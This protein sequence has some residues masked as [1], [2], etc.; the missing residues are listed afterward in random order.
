MGRTDDQGG[1]SI[2]VGEPYPHLIAADTGVN[3]QAQRLVAKTSGTGF[4]T[5][6]PGANP[7]LITVAIPG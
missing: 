4:G 7:M 6:A 5:C 3:D 2:S 1:R